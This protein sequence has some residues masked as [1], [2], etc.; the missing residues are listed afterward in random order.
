[1]DPLQPQLKSNFLCVS[2][3]FIGALS[4][5][6][7]SLTNPVFIAYLIEEWGVLEEEE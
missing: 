7:P 3:A 5:A 6:K 2:I 1:L 4:D